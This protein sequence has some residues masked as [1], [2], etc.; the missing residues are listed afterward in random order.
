MSIPSSSELVEISAGSSPA[1]SAR[2]SS[3]LRSRASEPW[4]GRAICSSA[5]AFTRAA[6]RS[7]CARLFTNTS[8]VRDCRIY[9]STS[10]ATAGHTLPLTSPRSGTG[11]TTLSSIVFTSPQSTSVTGRYSAAA[12]SAPAARIPPRKCAT[13]SS[14]RCVADN[15]MRCTGDST[16]ISSRS[17]VSARCTPRLVPATA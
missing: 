2:S 1:L 15:P 6:I 5:S 8:V 13:S 14:G 3:S 17:S 4:Y 10:S 11:D 16:S 9:A 12:P 7:A